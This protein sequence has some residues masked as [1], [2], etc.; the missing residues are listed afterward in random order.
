MVSQGYNIVA[1]ADDVAIVL[2]GVYPQT[3]C[4][5]IENV[6]NIL[7]KWAEKCGLDVNPAKIELVVFT[8]NQDA[9]PRF[10][11]VELHQVGNK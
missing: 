2:Q 3:L 4:D 8:R 7:S 5:L 10:T 9:G 1:Y 11:R 6:L